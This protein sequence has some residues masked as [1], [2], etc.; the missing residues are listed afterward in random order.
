MN[1]NWVDKHTQSLPQKNYVVTFL[2]VASDNIF[3][4]FRN[5]SSANNLSDFLSCH[6][7]LVRTD[8]LA[9]LLLNKRYFEAV[10][11]IIFSYLISLLA[12]FIL[13]HKQ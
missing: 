10:L 13:T 11:S 9:E 5:I 12:A 2:Y 7:T 8:L 3:K 1:H 6:K 4:L